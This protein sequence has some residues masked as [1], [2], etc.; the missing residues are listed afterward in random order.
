LAVIRVG[1]IQMNSTAD[2]E[3]NLAAA[4]SLVG[5]AARQGAELIALPENFAYLRREGEPVPCAQG[6]DGEIV[7]AVRSLAIEHRVW[8][9]GGTF[10]ETIPGSSRIHN[11][12]VLVSADGEIEAVYRKIHLFDIDLRNSGGSAFSESAVVAPGEEVVVAR[13]PFGAIGLSVCYDVRFPELYRA[14]AERGARWI[15]VPSAFTPETGKDHWEVLLRA[16]AIENQAY[17][18][19]PAQCGRHSEERRS[20]GRSLIVDPWGL[21]LARAGDRPSAV[22]ADC[23]LVA[24]EDIRSAL[25]A[26]RHRR[27]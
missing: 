22:V 19:A 16:R 4:R 8:L 27:L 1:V 11:T 5:T 21:V 13:T 6:L 9:L 18:L 15:A 2:L 3:A 17:V 23:D 26:L 14:M 12:S 24:L 7:G 20:Y 25:P 10:P